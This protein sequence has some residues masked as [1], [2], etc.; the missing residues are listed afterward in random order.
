[1]KNFS[2]INLSKMLPSFVTLAALC[3]G[4]SAIRYAMD[5]KW[6]VAVSLILVAA[7]LDGIDG[8]IARALKSES[9]F[10]AELDS[11]ADIISFGIAP[12]IVVYMWSLYEIPYKGVGWTAVL[13]YM[14]CSAIRLAKFNSNLASE[15]EKK[16]LQNYFTGLPTPSAAFL[17]LL[18]MI[19]SFQFEDFAV[20]YWLVFAYQCVLGML[21]ISRVPVYSFKKITFSRAMVIP[22]YALFV[23]FIGLLMF[24]PWLMISVV[25][26]GIII[27]IFLSCYTYY[28]SK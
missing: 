15:F 20:S 25:G 11:L 22:A 1:M 19:I 27:S 9:H 24:Q 23:L 28:R 14:C 21:M 26:I 17:L 16:K 13:F 2:E 5:D 3:I 7:L 18:P 12:A 6:A 10:G 4:V 8:R